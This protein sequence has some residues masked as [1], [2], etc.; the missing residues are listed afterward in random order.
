MPVDSLGVR[1]GPRPKGNGRD[2]RRLQL[3]TEMPRNEHAAD[4]ARRIMIDRPPSGGEILVPT[5]PNRLVS[6]P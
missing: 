1:T 5:R 4:A 2:P 6:G 3:A